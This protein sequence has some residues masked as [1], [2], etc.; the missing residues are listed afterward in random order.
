MDKNRRINDFIAD[1]SINSYQFSPMAAHIRRQIHII[2]AF[3]NLSSESVGSAES[4]CTIITKTKETKI[5]KDRRSIDRFL[6]NNQASVDE[7]ARIIE[8]KKNKPISN[9]SGSSTPKAKLKPAGSQLTPGT[10]VAF[11]APPIDEDNVGHKM[12]AAMG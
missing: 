2:A 10:V 9:T 12:L 3:Y 1:E 8:K 5:P 4:R 7:Q 6:I 11:N